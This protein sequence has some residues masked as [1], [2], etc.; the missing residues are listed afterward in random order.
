MNDDFLGDQ[1]ELK[2]EFAHILRESSRDG[3]YVCRYG[4]EEFSIIFT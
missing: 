4:G 3:D 1:N 2:K